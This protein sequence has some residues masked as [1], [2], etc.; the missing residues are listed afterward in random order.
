MNEYIRGL[1]QYVL[2]EW[3]RLRGRSNII[4]AICFETYR[5]QKEISRSPA[6]LT[7]WSPI[8]IHTLRKLHLIRMCLKII[9]ESFT[10]K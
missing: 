2:S 4:K 6:S 8:K 5:S 9:L 1:Y 7:T 3:W 10:T